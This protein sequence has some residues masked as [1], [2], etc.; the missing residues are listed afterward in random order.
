[1]VTIRVRIRVSGN[2]HLFV[3]LAFVAVTLPFV[4]RIAGSCNSPISD[5]FCGILLL[6]LT[7]SKPRIQGFKK[8][9]HTL[10][11]CRSSLLS[12]GLLFRLNANV[13]VFSQS[14]QSPLR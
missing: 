13:F 14:I 10:T 3:P 6:V 9:V 4:W 2:A 11:I 7:Q 5:Q 12:S 1:M 8:R